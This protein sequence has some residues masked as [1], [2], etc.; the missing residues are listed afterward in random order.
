MEEFAT[1]CGTNTGVGGV[2]GTGVTGV[3]CSTGVGGVTGTGA[4]EQ[5]DTFTVADVMFRLS[6]PGWNAY[7]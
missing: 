6:L 5:P 4:G 2:T 3:G 1:G 7:T